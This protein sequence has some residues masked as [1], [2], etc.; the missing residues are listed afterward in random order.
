[1]KEDVLKEILEANQNRENSFLAEYACK[2]ENGI[3]FEP[4]KEKIQDELNIRQSFFHDT[5]KIIHSSAYTRYIDKTQVFSFFE[6]DNITHRV[7]HVQFVSKIARVI[8]RALKLNEDLIEAIALGHDIG[9]TPYGHTGEDFINR[10]YKKYNMGCFAHNAQSVRELM[11]VEDGG[12]GLNLTLQVL[13]GILTHNGEL[14]QNKYIPDYNKTKQQFLEQYNN[15][16]KTDNF[17]KTIKPMTLEGCVVRICDIIAYVGRD[18]EDAI[19]VNLIRREELP[20]EA[21]DILGNT[22]DKIINTLVLDVIEN[23][24]NREYI[25]FSEDVFNALTILKKFNKENIYCVAMQEEDKNKL[26][27]MFIDLFDLYLYDL[28]TENKNSD[29]YKYFLSNKNIKYLS[30]TTL[31]QRVS[32]YIC[33]MTDDFL[34]SSY[35]KNFLPKNWGIKLEE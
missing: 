12:N 14:V 15:C 34:Y 13:D 11:Y 16:F 24:M 17:T 21:I 27:K 25:G 2:S 28:D 31:L 29:I 18:I 23:S 20:K 8:G 19:L 22:N 7:L 35:V 6:N 4:E 26:E 9:H 5:D 30:E 1:M 32:D 33:G 3:R 10:I